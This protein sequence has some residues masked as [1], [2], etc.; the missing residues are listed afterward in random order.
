M[1]A[2]NIHKSCSYDG[3]LKA[4]IESLIMAD[5]STVTIV[6]PVTG[7]DRGISHIESQTEANNNVVV[8]TLIPLN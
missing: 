5:G 3:G 6:T 2:F 1:P 7:P 8:N 4:F